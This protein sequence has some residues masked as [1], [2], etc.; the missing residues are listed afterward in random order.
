MNGW[1]PN[2][3]PIQL[4]AIYKKEDHPELFNTLDIKKGYFVKIKSDSDFWIEDVN[5]L[6]TT[7][8]VSYIRDFGIDVPHSNKYHGSA[9]IDFNLVERILTPAEH[10]TEHPECYL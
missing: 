7:Q 9:T 10:K 4:D 1:Y 6:G 5:L 8:K 3:M 2:A